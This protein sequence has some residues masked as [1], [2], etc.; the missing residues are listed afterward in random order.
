MMLISFYIFTCLIGAFV[1]GWLTRFSFRH[2]KFMIKEKKISL[3]PA[4]RGFREKIWMTFG[5]GVT[6][7]G[8]YF[9]LIYIS[10]KLL[11]SQIGHNF[12]HL[13]YTY[14]TEFIYLGLFIFA[15]FTLSI[16]LVRMF[17]KYIFLSKSP[18]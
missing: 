11:T 2:L 4:F 3:K 7:F 14:P 10:S 6:F 12:F 15:I 8:F 13:V 16:Y 1:I 5:L 17:I 9:I 18:R